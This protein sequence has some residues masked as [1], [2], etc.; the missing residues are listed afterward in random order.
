MFRFDIVTIG[1]ITFDIF[2]K[3]F[4]YDIVKNKKF[5]SQKG[6]ALDYSSKTG[7]DQLE[8]HSGGGALNT[9]VL[10]SNFGLKTAII[11]RLGNDFAAQ[12]IRERIKECQKLD[13]SL[14]QTD[15]RF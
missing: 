5:I 9:G 13:F 2:L 8:Y 1:S 3:G 4:K 14:L 7:V 15:D 11:S 12:I 6:L 10:F